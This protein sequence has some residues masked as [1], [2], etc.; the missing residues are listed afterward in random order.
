MTSYATPAR[1]RFPRSSD[2]GVVPAALA[3]GSFAINW[4]DKKLYVG[5]ASGVPLRITQW[6]ED[7]TSTR[8]YRQ[9]DF[10]IRDA[11]MYRARV[12]L[13][14]N[15]PFNLLQWEIV[16]GSD[17]AKVSEPF[18]SSI[19]SGGAVTPGA[20]AF[21][22]NIAAGTGIMVSGDGLT[23]QAVEVAWGS[24]TLTLA[25]GTPRWRVIWVQSDGVVTSA[26]MT[27]IIGTAR[28]SRVI[29]AY[30]LVGDAGIA[31]IIAGQVPAGD[32]AEA[33]RDAYYIDGGAYR[34]RGLR[35]KA[36]TGLALSITEGTVFD[37]GGNWRVTPENPNLRAFAARAAAPMQYTSTDR[38]RGAPRATI[39]PTLWDNNTATLQAV[40]PTSVTI[41]YVSMNPA[42]GAVSVQ[43]G[44]ALYA[45]VSAALEALPDDW[46]AR[47][48]FSSG[49]ANVLLGALIMR[50]DT[51]T[52]DGVEVVVANNKGDP[53][54]VASAGESSQYF[55]VDGSRPL[56]ND[57]DAGG[58]A[59]DNAV[60][61]GGTF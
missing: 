42:T 51:V 56:T 20:G 28:R 27:Q 40:P 14:V 30:A 37:L 33:F 53:F 26:D 50:G 55:L 46:D 35:I 25:A 29:L 47:R 1:V 13:P 5:D 21:A 15:T 10:V 18:G 32:T 24:G 3:P 16:T 17:R 23:Q 48:A 4:A 59:I 36:A 49:R 39:D 60:I 12:D 58:H 45:T 43:Y 22:V 38:L 52:H 41:Q 7:W 11:E 9:G 2:T 61:D 31:Q 54:A 44:Q 8:A 57:M 19:L 34:A 6:I